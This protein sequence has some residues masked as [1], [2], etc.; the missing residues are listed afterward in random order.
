VP[1]ACVFSLPHFP[2]RG[3]RGLSLPRNQACHCLF[4]KQAGLQQPCFNPRKR[5]SQLPLPGQTGFL[6]PT[7]GFQPR[8][9]F[10]YQN[11]FFLL[12]SVLSSCSNLFPLAPEGLGPPF[13]YI[14][15][16]LAEVGSSVCQPLLFLVPHLG[17]RWT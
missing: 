3:V 5:F 15:L 6:L 4:S 13:F 9:D 16:D 1:D 17:E 14:L 12:L 11:V 7:L 8:T 10:S 2:C